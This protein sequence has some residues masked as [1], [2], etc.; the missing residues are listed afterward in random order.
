V[1]LAIGE[2]AGAKVAPAFMISRIG[3]DDLPKDVRGLLRLVAP[4]EDHRL[5][6]LRLHWRNACGREFPLRLVDPAEADQQSNELD[7]SNRVGGGELD[8]LHHM[9][10]RLFEFEPP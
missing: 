10:Q 6:T 8:G 9:P 7:A 1:G 5:Q 2:E 3:R 4:G